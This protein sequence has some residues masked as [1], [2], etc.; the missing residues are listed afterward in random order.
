MGTN[1]YAV[2]EP[3][4]TCGR[5]DERH[6]GKSSGGWCFSLHVYPDDGIHDL[7][8]WEIVWRNA[9]IRD[10]YGDELSADEMRAIITERAWAATTPHASQWYR[11]NH[12]MP[13][14]KGLARSAVDGSHC[15]GH[16]SGTWDL[17]VGDFS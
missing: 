13:G 5:G 12:A 7:P 3:C 9:T 1:Y 14:P 4:P 11:D 16:G 2:E 8:E 17:L 10:E 15:I 6:I